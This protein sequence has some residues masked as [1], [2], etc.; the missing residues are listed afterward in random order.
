MK[1]FVAALAASVLGAFAGAYIFSQILQTDNA[2]EVYLEIN[3]SELERMVF[4]DIEKYGVD[5]YR[6][7]LEISQA[8]PGLPGSDFAVDKAVK[9]LAVTYPDSNVRRIA[10][11]YVVYGAIRRRDMIQIE[12][13]LADAEKEGPRRRFM[14]N[15][16]EIEPQLIAAQYNY[17][18]H[19]GRFADAEKTLDY[20]DVKFADSFIFQ[21]QGKPVSVRAFISNQR[22]VLEIVK[23]RV[24]E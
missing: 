21:P 14:P 4:G 13:Y 15:G 23:R 22:R 9:K 5:I 8:L 11:A 7:Y 16:F 2:D 1:C 20:L 18:F 10:D 6:L 24:S 3:R 17:Y 19:I 12:R